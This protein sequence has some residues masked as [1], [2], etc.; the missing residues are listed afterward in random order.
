MGLEI[1]PSKTR[2]C[3]TLHLYDEQQDITQTDTKNMKNVGNKIGFN[4]LGFNIRQ[5]SEGKYQ[6][7]KKPNGE[8][9]GYKT[10][11]KPSR[12]AVKRHYRKLVETVDKHRGL[13][14]LSLITR[15]NPIIRG[16]CNYFSTTV[17]KEIFHKIDSLLYWKLT[18]WGR[19]RH[20]NRKK[21]VASKYFHQVGDN[22]WN[23]AAKMGNGKLL[24]LH[25]HVKT[26]ILRHIKVKGNASP[27]NGDS[28]Y[29][30]TRM[31]RNPEMPERTATLLKRQKG[32]CA[33][34]GLTF[35][36]GD[37][38]EHDHIKPLSLGGEKGIKNQQLL[39]R[40]CHD[41]KTSKDD[42]YKKNNTFGV[43]KKHLPD[44]YKWVDDILILM[45]Q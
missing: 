1:S 31:G 21:F 30:S 23:F 20:N 7:G 13:T 28:V 33:H 19:K 32:K 24:P 15:L 2:I 43:N 5:Y 18:K 17:S 14:Q 9:L 40:H 22:N 37:L 8:L 36:Y 41:K 29:W 26:P 25:F 38:L 35:K 39:H 44:E 34:C 4:F 12:E 16:W 6:S 27:Y 11:I 10:L 3:H 45:S 42:S